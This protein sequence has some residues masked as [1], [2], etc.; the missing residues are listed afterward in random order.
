VLHIHTHQHNTLAGVASVCGS[1]VAR[2]TMGTFVDHLGPRYGVAIFATLTSSAAF[3]MALIQNA[4]A[5][6]ACRLLIGFSLATFVP[7]QFWCTNMFNARIVGQANAV[8]AGWGNL[9]GGAT[10]LLMPLLVE[11]S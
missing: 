10:L 5:F 8:A 2:V 11:V 6:I 4:S 9:G 3:C 1:V 7:C